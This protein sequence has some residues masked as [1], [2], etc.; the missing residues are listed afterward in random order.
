[1]EEADEDLMHIISTKPDPLLGTLDEHKYA[2]EWHPEA[3]EVEVEEDL[4]C[5]IGTEPDPLLG[6]SDECNDS[7]HLKEEEVAEGVL[8]CIISAKPDLL[9]GT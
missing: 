8:V 5:I 9:P 2:I 4:T 1:M 3:E 7:W 6:A